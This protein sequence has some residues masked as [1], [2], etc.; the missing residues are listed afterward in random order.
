MALSKRH[1]QLKT[2]IYT[3]VQGEEGKKHLYKNVS[4]CLIF[5]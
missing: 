1:M 3:W 4:I 2:E 5:C